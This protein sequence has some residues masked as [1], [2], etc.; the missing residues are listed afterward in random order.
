[1]KRA[2]GLAVLASALAAS[3]AATDLWD[4]L[5]DGKPGVSTDSLKAALAGLKAKTP[6][7]DKRPGLDDHYWVTLRLDG[8]GARG[9][10]AKLG[11]S[12][13]TI[14]GS[15]VSGTAD[16]GTLSRL[17]AAGIEVQSRRSLGSLGP[18]DFPP[19]DGIYHNYGQV[20]SELQGIA[21]SAQGFGSSIS[22]G[23][24]L[25]GRSLAGVKLG[26]PSRDGKEKPAI[27]FLGTHHARE[28]LS[29][30]VPLLLA[31]WL[32]DHSREPRVKKL[33][34]TR[35]V[36]IVP[37]VNPDG[38]EYDIATGSYRWQRKN[39]RDNGDGTT[40]VD[41]NRNYDFRFGGEGASDSPGSDTYH[42]PS[43]FSEPETRAVRDFVNG[44]P[45]LKL[46]VSY[47]TFSELILYPWGGANE[48]IPDGRA[49]AAYKAMA[50]KM[51]QWT[52][53]TPE[54]SSALYVASGDTCDWAYGS[55]GIFCFT[56][57]LTP[58]SQ[59]QG[60]FYPGGG[61][62]ST[63]FQKNIEPALYMID[64]ADDPYRAGGGNS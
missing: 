38:V 41:L 18:S 54:Q 40:G 51:A 8:P 15:L 53:Y 39:M 50:G 23:N 42:G 61:A 29:T 19:S 17:Q 2:L 3:A 7:S 49:L 62:V 56:F 59:W 60:G 37:L 11:V 9:Q 5:F 22:I 45:N 10:A 52:G 12:I 4:S 35:D 44:L 57:E 34:E 16:I 25:Q 21:N 36:Y 13:E 27:A 30:E 6:E 48:P 20:L 26:Y 46:L 33:L 55:K 31:R 28:H 14:E 58:K 63:T 47:H 32:V 43:A 1:M 24:S 64:L